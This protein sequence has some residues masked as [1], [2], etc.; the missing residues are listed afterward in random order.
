[1]KHMEIYYLIC[2]AWYI[3]ILTAQQ[4]QMLNR[5]LCTNW[6]WKDLENISKL[7]MYDTCIQLFLLHNCHD[8]V[9]FLCLKYCQLLNKHIPVFRS[10]TKPTFHWV[11]ALS[12]L[13]QILLTDFINVCKI[14][15]ND[16]N[17]LRYANFA[18]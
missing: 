15:C 16:K 7:A 6:S 13:T 9:I 4:R 14:F 3:I 11:K 8:S 5:N 18:M 17:R 1:M 12:F 2:L 10:R